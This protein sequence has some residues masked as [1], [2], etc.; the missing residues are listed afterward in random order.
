MPTIQKSTLR[1]QLI[2]RVQT[3]LDAVD[4]DGDGAVDAAERARLPAD[5]R[6]LAD[7]TA[8]RYL[9]GGPMSIPDYVAAY[10]DY[11]RG[12]L[13]A[14]DVNGDGRMQVAEQDA[15][16][17]PLYKSLLAMRAAAPAPV[18]PPAAPPASPPPSTATGGALG[19]VGTKGPSDVTLRTVASTGLNTPTGI[20]FD[21]RT[22]KLWVV[23]R[24]DDSSVVV[25]SPTSSSPTSKKYFDDSAH[26]MNNP[27]HI[28]FS[29]TY[30]EMATV[31]DTTND[32]NGAA[33][34]NMF[35]GPTLWP[36]DATYTGGA[37][38]HL[39]MLHHSPTA[40]GIAAGTE[41]AAQR[42]YWVVNGKDGVVD[43]YFFGEP[44]AHGADDHSDGITLR[45]GAAG[46]LK[47]KAGLPSHAAL[48]DDGRTL[49]VADTGN[50]RIAKLDTT[51]PY[52]NS[53][54]VQGHHDET[55]LYKVPNASIKALTGADA[56]LVAPVG[57]VVHQGHLVVGDYGTGHVKVFTKSGNL[58][59]DLDTGL[60]SNALGGLAVGPNG[61]LFVTDMKTNKVFE[62]TIR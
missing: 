3:A 2:D 8:D 14:G 51:T 62:L 31:Q 50:G 52:Q 18:D 27:M 33:A 49:Y 24:A 5:V 48:D 19:I 22:N 6:D 60:G 43:R 45:Y 38:S 47:R 35:M 9:G 56:G 23:N 13:D 11:A 32:Y 59:G 53:T 46:S 61:K 26:F 44:H 58:V 10:T 28:A 55:P 1:N 40:I 57:L 21:P 37:A 20:A 12:A 29:P 15:L 36:T 41:Y 7:A 30:A 39:D 17:A 25:S 4:A 16:P 54:R 34:G 42:E